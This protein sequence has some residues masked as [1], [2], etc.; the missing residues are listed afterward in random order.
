MTT[1]SEGFRLFLQKELIR[2]CGENRQY[3]LRA[4]ARDLG[5]NSAI[6]STILSRKRKITEKTIHRFGMALELSPAQIN[7][8]IVAEYTKPTSKKRNPTYQE[9]AQ[10]A[11]VAISDWYHDAILELTHLKAFQPDTKWIAQTLN[12]SKI[13]IDAAV[14]RLQRLELLEIDAKGKWV[15]ISRDNSNTLDSD[16]TNAAMK[17]YQK[18]ILEK[19]MAALSS[20]PR[21]DRDHTSIMMAA[22]PKDLKAAKE[23]IAEF[24][25]ELCAFFQRKGAKP[26]EV[27]QLAVGL[28]PITN[29]KIPEGKL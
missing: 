15:D 19:S 12:V 28:F 3:S 5:V 14:E 17:K 2:R 13:E 1:G 22:D 29:L 8:F 9:L 26:A 4:F 11:F 18:Q 21:T 20:L 7:Q 23:M 6:L 27:Y 10:D 16:F 24:R 25:K